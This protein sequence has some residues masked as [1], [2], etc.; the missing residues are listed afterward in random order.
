MDNE[1]RNSALPWFVLVALALHF[2]L[3]QI[4]VPPTG[5]LTAES[6][7]AA[8]GKNKTKE[9]IVEH[10]EDSK[11]PIVRS[12][13]AKNQDSAKDKEARF[14]GEFKQRVEKETQSPDKGRFHEGAIARGKGG[15]ADGDS[16]PPGAHPE[17]KGDELSQTK[18]GEAGKGGKLGMHDLL[19]FGASPNDL[20]KDIGQGNETVLNTDPVLYAS[21]INRIADEIY[22]PWA[23][24]AR[25][26]VRTYYTLGKKLEANVYVTKLSVLMDSSGRVSAIQVLQSSGIPELDEAPKKAFWSIEPFPNPPSQMFGKDGYVKLVYSFS[27]QL[28]TSSFNIVPWQI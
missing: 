6:D 23:Q 5:P 22:D 24:N 4:I 10:Y 18:P 21:F 8:Q 25:E 9:I 7:E 17:E 1:Y 2:L 11:K 12:S 13:R 16:K 20:P 3:A 19:A 26:A 27:F 14:A 15:D 28:M